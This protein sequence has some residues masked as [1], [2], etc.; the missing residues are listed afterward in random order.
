VPKK[1]SS[2][3]CIKEGEKIV[4][5]VWAIVDK[6]GGIMMGFPGN[7]HESISLVMEKEQ[8]LSAKQIF[9]EPFIGP[10][11]ISFHKS[12][13]IK[14]NSKMGKTESAKDR[15]TVV[16]PKLE[17]IDDPIRMAEILLPKVLP[18]KIHTPTS[19]DILLDITDAQSPP[20]RL[21]ISCM[22]NRHFDIFNEGKNKIIN[23]SIFECTHA[24]KTDTHTWVWTLRKSINDV[25]YSDKIYIL[26]PGEVKW[27]MM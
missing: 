20:T 22:A 24:L 3:I 8:N 19:R 26:L 16:G 27:G 11:K 14:L 25:Q 12:G 18:G 13:H 7:P 5:L 6:E 23:T 4:Y 10:S 15:V 17:N 21:T 2:K 9:T 1:K